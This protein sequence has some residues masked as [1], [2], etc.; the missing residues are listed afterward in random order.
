MDVKLISEYIKNIGMM[1]AYFKPNVSIKISEVTEVLL[2]ICISLC[3]IMLPGI[4][5]FMA[6]C[7]NPAYYLEEYG[8]VD[9]FE[10]LVDNKDS[11][12]RHKVGGLVITADKFTIFI[13]QLMCYIGYVASFLYD[14]LLVFINV[15]LLFQFKK[16]YNALQSKYKLVKFDNL[17]FVFRFVAL[18]CVAG[19]IGLHFETFSLISITLL[20]IGFIIG[21]I[22]FI[23]L[24]KEWSAYSEIKHFANIWCIYFIGTF[25]SSILYVIAIYQ[26]EEYYVDGGTLFCISIILDLILSIVFYAYIL[27]KS[28]IVVSEDKTNVNLVEHVGQIQDAES[29]SNSDNQ[30]EEDEEDFDATDDEVDEEELTEVEE[31]YKEEVE[32]LLE[33]G[34][35][36]A[37]GRKLLERKRVRWEISEERANEIEQMCF[38]PSLSDTEQ[39]SL[40]D[41]E[42]EYI[43]I[44]KEISAEGEMTDRKRRMLDR[45]RDLLGISQERAKELETN[46]LI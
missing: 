25:I 39:E 33:D 6:E 13:T 14:Y 22:F 43:E 23:L 34:A 31:K 16:I 21:S 40:S 10:W 44:Y 15:F 19:V 24:R 27:Q 45:E 18:G 12:F 29:L 11:F 35:I 32:F 46:C 41:E 20:L 7:P 4:F 26:M 37:E 5:I 42:K 3:C 36:D 17:N 1:K 38:S 28:C 8:C 2:N 30:D 9:I